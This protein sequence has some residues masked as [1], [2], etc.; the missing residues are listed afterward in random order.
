MDEHLF[1]IDMA[2]LSEVLKGISRHSTKRDV[3]TFREFI[4]S[5]LQ[6]SP[7]W[8]GGVKECGGVDEPLVSL[9]IKF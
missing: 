3:K 4:D 1:V 2:E 5:T 8:R 6:D 7:D 9:R